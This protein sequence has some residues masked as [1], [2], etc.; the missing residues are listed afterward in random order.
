M[1]SFFDPIVRFPRQMLCRA[2]ETCERGLS[3]EFC[4]IVLPLSSW[5]LMLT[6]LTI[7]RFERLK[8]DLF[9]VVDKWRLRGI[10]DF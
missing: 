9:E 7:E 8:P 5:I 10:T 1:L 6:L 4:E 3:L 2:C